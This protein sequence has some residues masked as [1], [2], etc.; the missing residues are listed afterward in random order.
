MFLYRY[1]TVRILGLLYSF[2]FPFYLHRV[3]LLQL[4]LLLIATTRFSGTTPPLPPYTHT[5]SLTHSFT[6]PP[7]SLPFPHPRH[8]P[9]LSFTCFLS[10]SSSFLP[11]SP[12]VSVLIVFF[13]SSSFLLSINPLFL[14]FLPHLLDFPPDHP[15]AG[16]SAS[17]HHHTLI[18]PSHPSFPLPLPPAAY[19]PTT[20]T[21]L[22]TTTSTTSVLFSCL[23]SLLPRA[24]LPPHFKANSL[25]SSQLVIEGVV[26]PPGDLF[27]RYRSFS[28]LFPHPP[29]PSL[30][31][32]A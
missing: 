8:S 9:S 30:L 1:W 7:H 2:S 25:F 14:L 22:R 29:I 12:F 23:L 13:S 16:H 3:L 18:H 4:N 31:L 19:A 11:F 28:D 27:S 24:L 26:H 32:P 20:A 21:K 6:Y 17:T 15:A 5:H 10:S